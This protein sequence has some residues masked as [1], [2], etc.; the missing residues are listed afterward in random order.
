MKQP[1]VSTLIEQDFSD[2]E[3]ALARD[4][5]SALSSADLG[6]YATQTW[7]SDNFLSDADFREFVTQEELES[8]TS[9]KM[10]ATESSAFYP[11][12][13]N[14]EGYLTSVPST[15]ATKQYVS[16]V[17]QG[18]TSWAEGEFYPLSNPSHFITSAD[19]PQQIEYT[20]GQYI[21]IDQNNVITA[22]GLQPELPVPTEAT[23]LVGTPTGKMRWKARNNFM[24]ISD[25]GNHVLTQ[26]DLNNGYFDIPIN[27][28]V[29]STSKV[30][31]FT[32]CMDLSDM[33]AN[34]GSGIIYPLDTRVEKIKCSIYNEGENTWYSN[35]NAHGSDPLGLVFEDILGSELSR[36][37]SYWSLNKQVKRSGMTGPWFLSFSGPSFRVVFVQNHD[38]QVGDKIVMTGRISGINFEFGGW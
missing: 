32:F 13:S 9:G 38:L 35:D 25:L 4:N 28:N 11:R 21:S 15:Y 24:Y 20:A 37:A 5:I 33:Y 17:A 31:D 19:V 18:I 22:S 12:Y 3:K 23:Y 1:Y 2:E 36:V 34:R 30:N 10:D 16:S 27:W 14:P 8:A 6:P 7:V 29:P 26:D